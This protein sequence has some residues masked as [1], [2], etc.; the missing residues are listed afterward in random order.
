M[1]VGCTK[2]VVARPVLAEPSTQWMLTA[3]LRV[4]VFTVPPHSRQIPGGIHANSMWPCGFH[5]FHM[6]YFW[7]RA[8]PF[9][10]KFPCS[11]H[12][13]TPWNFNIPWNP[14]EI[15]HILFH[16]IHGL[17]SIPHGFHI[18]PHYS[19]WIPYYSTLFHMDSTLFHMDSTFFHMDST[20]FHIESQAMTKYSLWGH[21][22][23]LV[24]CSVHWVR[25]HDFPKPV[26]IFKSMTFKIITH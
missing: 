17:H 19:T 11:F 26:K 23:N 10:C 18:I 3:K 16:G 24:F 9:W 22:P 2:V 21:Q 14:G 4:E 5:G 8:Q 25:S 12:M 7:L 20:F 13:E 1:V 15:H 6:E